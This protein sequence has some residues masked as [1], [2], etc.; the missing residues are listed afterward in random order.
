MRI[1][2]LRA[3]SD[4]IHKFPWWHWRYSAVRRGNAAFVVPRQSW[5]SLDETQ[6]S[7]HEHEQRQKQ[8][9]YALLVFQE[10]FDWVIMSGECQKRYEQCHVPRWAAWEEPWTNSEPHQ[11]TMYFPLIK[12]VVKTIMNQEWFI[13]PTY[14][15]IGEWFIIVLTTLTDV[16]CGDLG[17]IFDCYL[18][19]LCN[20]LLSQSSKSPLL[21]KWRALN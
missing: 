8:G 11:K 10:H 14:R 6:D 18:N 2:Q 1:E 5:T 15:E 4:A 16:F 13:P 17:W 7:D 3:L 19:P 21:I 9:L 12:Y 20:Q